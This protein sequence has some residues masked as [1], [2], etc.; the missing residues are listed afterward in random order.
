MTNKL[1]IKERVKQGKATAKEG[2]ALL[3][4]RASRHAKGAGSDPDACIA[5]AL[6]SRT[7][8]WLA[9]RAKAE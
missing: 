3:K 4:A 1:G 2:L 9:R 5:R 7:G 8:Q 6:S